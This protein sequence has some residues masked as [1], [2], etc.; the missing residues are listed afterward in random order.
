MKLVLISTI[1]YLSLPFI[2][3]DCSIQSEC[4]DES[5]PT[6]QPQPAEGGNKK[7]RLYNDTNTLCPEF[8]GI[9]RCCTPLQLRKL[10]SSFTSLESIFGKSAGGC[11]ICVVNMKRFWCHFTCDQIKPPS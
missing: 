4:V 3:S 2:H 10:Q 7:P 6:C 9:E 8:E 5:S 1:S 11:D